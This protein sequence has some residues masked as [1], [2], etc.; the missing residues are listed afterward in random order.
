MHK[1]FLGK[2]AKLLC[3]I[4]S[5]ILNLHPIL[6]T[7][8]FCVSSPPWISQLLC[9]L[10]IYISSPTAERF[11]GQANVTQVTP[12]NATLTW[13]PGPQNTDYYCVVVNNETMGN[14]TELTYDLVN[15]TAGTHYSFQV[16]PVKCSRKLNPQAIAFYT[17]EFEKK[18]FIFKNWKCKCHWVQEESSKICFFITFGNWYIHNKQRGTWCI[19]VFFYFTVFN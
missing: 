19:C 10:T 13:L 7:E 15:L 18:L 4:Y 9:Q 12:V 17:S 11:F 5:F 6:H 16:F 2:Y 3:E 1:S 14:V 8:V